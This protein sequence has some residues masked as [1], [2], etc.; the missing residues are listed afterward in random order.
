MTE[1]KSRTPSKSE[2]IIRLAERASKSHTLSQSA[3]DDI[4]K[5]VSLTQKGVPDAAAELHSTAAFAVELLTWLC[6]TRPE[7]FATIAREKF[8]WPVMYD[9]HPE[10]MRE[11]AL[12]IRTLKLGSNTQINLSSGKTFSWQVPANVIAIQLHGLAQSL[13]RAPM[14]SWNTLD[15]KHVAECG[16]GLRSNNTHIYND[17]YV[18]QLKALEKWGQ[19][20]AGK[21]LPPLAKQTAAQWASATKGL[22]LVAYGEN[23]DDHPRLQE[24][25]ES[26]LSRAKDY[27][28]KPGGRGIIRKVM[29]QAVKQA[30]HSISAR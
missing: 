8:A 29:R 14:R 18:K 22:F 16:V 28:G 2:V 13:Q 9:P 12:F 6:E 21:G 30:W 19:R 26:V 7:L 24:L 17:K 27:L 11:N 15:L 10:R 5:L 23:F 4:A 3:K 1:N 25:K 20:G